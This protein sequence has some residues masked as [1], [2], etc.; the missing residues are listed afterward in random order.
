MAVAAVAGYVGWSHFY[1]SGIRSADRS[2]T[3]GGQTSVAIPVTI[4]QAQTADFAVYLNGLGTVQPY[5]TVTVHSRV[6][7]ELTKVAFKQGQM[8]SE[9]ELLAQI[10]PRPYQAALDAGPKRGRGRRPRSRHSS[11]TRTVGRGQASH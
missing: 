10:D 5:E 11:T 9:G 8:V 3:K 6:D 4:A 2:D 1:G 7:G